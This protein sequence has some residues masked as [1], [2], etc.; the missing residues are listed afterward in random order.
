MKKFTRIAR[1]TNVD[2]VAN[3]LFK[4]PI[5]KLMSEFILEKGH[6]NVSIA[7]MDL[8]NSHVKN[9]MSLPAD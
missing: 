4:K 9:N 5:C 3:H 1:N 7:T 6:T 8:F 2:F